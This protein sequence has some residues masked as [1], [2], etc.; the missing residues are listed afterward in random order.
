[1]AAGV[2]AI[3]NTT[4][5]QVYVGAT[6]NTVVRWSMHRAD[7]K[8]GTHRNLMLQQDWAALGPEAF[9]FEMLE[10]VDGDRSALQDAEQ[11]WLEQLRDVAYNQRNARS[12]PVE[13]RPPLIVDS[14]MATEAARALAARRPTTEITCAVC[15]Q[16]KTVVA[17]ETQPAR[18]CSKVCR[19][20]LTYLESKT[21]AATT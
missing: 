13:P 6:Q 19:N 3:R 2:Y 17:R 9:K 4:T 14:A 18:T 7:L 1:M 21:R 15:G 8:R 5:G 10:A 12:V 16:R 11:R 20:R